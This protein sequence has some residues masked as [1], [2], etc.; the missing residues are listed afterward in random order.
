MS[1]RRR[2]SGRED[3]R[4][5]DK[6]E[7]GGESRANRRP[8]RVRTAAQIL[9]SG[10]KELPEESTRFADLCQYF[11]ASRGWTFRPEILEQ[12]GRC[13]RLAV[14]ERM[15]AMKEINQRA[16]GVPQ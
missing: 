9:A 11:S 6:F 16:N 14:P 5:L 8:Q 15:N 7:P 13:S 3:N 10:P 2:K 12:L 4:L 1:K